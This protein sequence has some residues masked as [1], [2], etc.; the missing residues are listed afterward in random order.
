[1]IARKGAGRVR[2]RVV[3]PGP[4][5]LSW[6][7][8]RP[9]SGSRGDRRPGARAPE[10]GESRGGGRRTTSA[11]SS[12]S[13][14]AGRRAT[15]ASSTPGSAASTTR[16]RQYREALDVRPDE[17]AVRYNLAV[18]LYKAA[19][20]RR[21]GQRARDGARGPARPPA[22]PLLLADC[23]L[24]LG[25]WKAVIAILD[26][27]L[28]KDPDNQAVLYMIGTALMRDRQYERGQRGA[29]PHPPA[30][31]TRPRP[32]WSSPSP[33]ARRHDDLAAEKELREGP[34]ARP[35]AA[36]R[37][38]LLG[39]VLVKMG[40]AP[41]RPRPCAGSSPST[42][43]TST[44]TCCSACCCGRTRGTTRP[45]STSRRRSSCGRGTPACATRSPSVHIATDE[46]EPA[47]GDPRAAGEGSPGLHR[48]PR[49]A[50]DGATTGSAPRGRRPAP[51]HRAAAARRRTRRG[52]TRRGAPAGSGAAALSAAR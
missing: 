24:L 47:R 40:E 3:R 17:V 13:R 37:E 22:A 16:S 41:R 18:A 30:R 12:S 8:R 46:L 42:R 21:G 25:E 29:R 5:P 33:A 14:G 48:G 19:R 43:T 31:A 6:S 39:E 23:H 45:S 34:R 36:H 51:G 50:R 38:R 2:N 52:A 26:P 10:G 44:R 1:M 9:G 20:F 35:A 7:P 4:S 15:W 27:L 32:T 11:S 28:E 49:L